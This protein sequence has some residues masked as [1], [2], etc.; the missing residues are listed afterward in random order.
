[1]AVEAMVQGVGTDQ[2]VGVVTAVTAATVAVTRARGMARAGMASTVARASPMAPAMARAL[3]M[4]TAMASQATSLGEVV[5]SP[6]A[7]KGTSSPVNRVEL[8]TNLAMRRVR[9]SLRISVMNLANSTEV[10]ILLILTAMA[11]SSTGLD[12]MDIVTLMHHLDMATMVDPIST[13][14]VMVEVVIMIL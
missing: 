3:P 8:H 7:A 14:L 5:V 1:M 4:A 2:A 9:T 10:H 13:I 11:I 6:A 12:H